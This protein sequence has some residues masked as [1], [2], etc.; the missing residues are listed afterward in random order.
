[1]LIREE[2]SAKKTNPRV[3]T[4]RYG[5]LED[6]RDLRRLLKL[7]DGLLIPQRLGLRRDTRRILVVLTREVAREPAPSLRL[8]SRPPNLPLGRF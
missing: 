8:F 2:V 7:G 4:S 1:M 5:S 6:P 3:Q